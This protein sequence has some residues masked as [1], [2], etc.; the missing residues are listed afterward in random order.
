VW[1][2]ASTANHPVDLASYGAAETTPGARDVALFVG[3]ARQLGARIAKEKT[4]RFAVGTT[5]II[6]PLLKSAIKADRVA[7]AYLVLMNIR[8]ILVY[9]LRFLLAKANYERRF[10]TPHSSAAGDDELQL[11]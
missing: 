5:R 6:R 8:C 3:P 11:C 1:R 2:S 10:G 9:P 7:S 4:C